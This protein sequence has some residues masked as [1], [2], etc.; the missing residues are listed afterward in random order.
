MIYTIE[1]KILMIKWFY[2]GNSYQNVL[3]MFAAL[4]PYRPIPG[5]STI[6]RTI[7]KF[8]T[9]GTVINNC[10]C[11]A[12]A[13]LQLGILIANCQRFL[14][15]CVIGVLRSA[16]AIFIAIAKNSSGPIF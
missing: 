2:Q 10:R 6:E 8:E 13:V 11:G 7:K 1:E 9:K 16:V 5:K 12:K 4:Y 3:N 14:R 15:V